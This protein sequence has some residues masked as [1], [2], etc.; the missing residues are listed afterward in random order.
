M[1]SNNY[2]GCQKSCSTVPLGERKRR[3]TGPSVKVKFEFRFWIISRY[4][5]WISWQETWMHEIYN[6][7]R[8]LP[9]LRVWAAPK[10]EW[11]P[12]RSVAA[13]SLKW[14]R[15]QSTRGKGS[16]NSSGTFLSFRRLNKRTK[17]STREKSEREKIKGLTVKCCLSEPWSS[18]WLWP[19]V[20]RCLLWGREKAEEEEEEVGMFS[21]GGRDWRRRYRR[22]E[23]RRR[24]IGGMHQ[25]PPARTFSIHRRISSSSSSSLTFLSLFFLL[26]P[27]TF[28]FVRSFVCSFLSFFF[29]D[30]NVLVGLFPTF[31][32]RSPRSFVLLFSVFPIPSRRPNEDGN[33]A[34]KPIQR[35][36]RFE[37]ILAPNLIHG[38]V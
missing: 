7:H 24:R 15:R 19:H 16:G 20:T 3:I 23:R 28:S 14:T 27:Y 30:W 6:W 12:R 38:G 25:T 35:E 2:Q 22:G 10:L 21:G 4:M 5:V 9:F 11:R 34:Q 32:R 8:F 18:N 33:S 1:K 37:K 31:F 26:S 29:R 17:W 36:F 13:D